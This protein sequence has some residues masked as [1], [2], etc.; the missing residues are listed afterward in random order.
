MLDKIVKFFSKKKSIEDTVGIFD[1]PD[2]INNIVAKIPK[3]MSQSDRKNFAIKVHTSKDTMV[4]IVEEL[5]HEYIQF[6]TRN[7][8]KQELTDKLLGAFRALDDILER[9][10]MWSAEY[11]Q[12]VE[13]SKPLKDDEKHPDYPMSS[14]SNI[15]IL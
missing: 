11:E 5:I 13:D 10:E 2:R 1:M 3:D 9:V 12:D 7:V 8:S 15:D 14:N 6:R 4:K